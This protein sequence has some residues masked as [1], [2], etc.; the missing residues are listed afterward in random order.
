MFT[1]LL[2]LPKFVQKDPTRKFN[3][4]KLK[5]R[6][7]KV[8]HY[9]PDRIKLRIA[10]FNDYFNFFG[11][12]MP[13]LWNI[14]R[15]SVFS[16]ANLK[17]IP[18]PPCLLAWG[19]RVRI[20]KLL[21]SPGIDSA[22]LCSLQGQSVKKGCGTCPPGWESISGFLKRF[23]NTGSANLPTD[24]RGNKSEEAH[25]FFTVVIFGS[26]TPH[27]PP[28]KLLPHLL[29]SLLVSHIYV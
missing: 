27:P 6:E 5:K 14:S 8:L 17:R 16:R 20:C 15:N 19:T 11:F 25:A 2:L 24:H 4:L 23:T 28:V 12:I 18:F 7:K 21:R 3:E 29:V 26:N 10:T 22:S 13:N 9:L 1:K